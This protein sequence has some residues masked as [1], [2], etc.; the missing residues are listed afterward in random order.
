MLNLVFL[1]ND[2]YS[3]PVSP[4]NSLQKTE[5]K[6]TKNAASGSQYVFQCFFVDCSSS[7]G[8]DILATSETKLL[9][10]ETTFSSCQA[11][12]GKG[13]GLY[14]DTTGSCILSKVCSFK[15]KSSSYGQFC[16][17]KFPDTI[18]YNN[19]MKDCSISCTDNPSKSSETRLYYGTILVSSI[20]SS[21]NKCDCWSGFCVYP[22]SSSSYSDCVLSFS[23]FSNN[24]MN[25]YMCV[26]FYGSSSKG[27]M[28]KCNVIKNSQ[29]SS[30]YG[31]VHTSGFLNVRE[32]CV[33][34]NSIPYAFSIVTSNQIN[35]YDSV[36]DKSNSGKVTIENNA[37]T[38]FLTLL[39]F[40]KTGDCDAEFIK[41]FAKP[42][43]S[44]D[45]KCTNL[46]R[47]ITDAVN[48]FKLTSMI[49]IST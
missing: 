8:G 37:A 39:M 45:R 9:I 36:F 42:K 23:C 46:K 41:T 12:S 21:F 13:G 6:E 24:N 4:S 16:Y 25:G 20:N 15:C 38:S 22:A 3:D 11:T 17:V 35:V 5:Y 18:G 1:W 14:F 48:I 32:S 40:I 2:F 28:R 34:E 31:A 44:Y 33:I 49:L 43:K 26:A 27:E 29:T 30:S 7:M 47:A 10:E 19:T